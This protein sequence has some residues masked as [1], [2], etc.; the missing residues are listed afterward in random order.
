MV[1]FT[2]QFF[3]LALELDDNWRVDKVLANYKLKEIEVFVSY[4][5]NQA[6]CPKTFDLCNI[7]DHGPKRRWR[8][9]D[10][11]QFQTYLVCSLPRIRDNDGKVVTVTPPWAAKS[12]RYT[13][14]FET[15][16]IEVLQ[17]TQNQT[18]S[19]CLMGCSF[20]QI[21]YIMHRAVERGLD[22]RP[23]NISYKHLS[24]DEK[25]FQ[26]GHNYVTVLS[27]PTAGVVIDVCSGRTKKETTTLLKEVVSEE[28]RDKIETVSMDMWKAYNESVKDVFPKTKRVHDRFHLIKYLNEALDKVRR[29]EV[30]TNEELK[31][32]RYALLKNPVNLTDKQQIKFEAI[33]NANYEVSRAWTIRENF[34]DI[35]GSATLREAVSLF[36]KW[37]GSV[38]SSDIKEM[39]KIAQMFNRHLEGVCNAL[40]ETFSNA[41]AERLNG[42]IQEVKSRA[43]GYRTFK[44]FRSA[45][46]FFHGGLQLYPL[47]SQ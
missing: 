25:A 40:V 20:D 41:M 1:G 24:I 33:R 30:K 32:S 37:S 34:K 16:A 26:K 8:H 38:A 39:Y 11:L 44:N 18:K 15:R 29:R 45:I 3:D 12:S 22:R 43:R 47:N 17:A 4:I 19:A 27:S 2:E 46:L 14:L 42:K 10:I 36:C 21:N 23:N 6:E 28:N 35:F 5:G 7:Y 31:N 13:H 9:L